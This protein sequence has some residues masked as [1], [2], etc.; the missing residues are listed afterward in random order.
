MVTFIAFSFQVVVIKAIMLAVHGHVV[1]DF[2]ARVVEVVDDHFGPR[3]CGSP[4]RSALPERSP[5]RWVSSHSS[6]NPGKLPGAHRQYA[7]WIGRK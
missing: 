7:D 2:H 3:G 5:N 6:T 1:I 4:T